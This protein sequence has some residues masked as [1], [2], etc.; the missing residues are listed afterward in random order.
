MRVRPV[1]ARILAT[2]RRQRHDDDFQQELDTHLAML[3]ADN[4]PRGMS[5]PDAERAARLRLGPLEALKAGHRDQRG[6]P[7]VESL[8][9]DLRFALRLTWKERWFSAAAIVALAIGI[10]ANGVGFSI[11]N[12]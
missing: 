12:A 2:M 3:V 7:S 11:V 10:G 9:Q 5:A 1:I 6:L 8:W 4:L